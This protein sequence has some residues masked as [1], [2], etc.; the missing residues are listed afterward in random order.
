MASLRKNS[1]LAHAPGSS[2]VDPS[3]LPCLGAWSEASV[4]RFSGGMPCFTEAL[5]TSVSPLGTSFTIPRSHPDMLFVR[6]R[7]DGPD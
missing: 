1:L 4:M 5:M 3:R 2:A 7:R 6:K